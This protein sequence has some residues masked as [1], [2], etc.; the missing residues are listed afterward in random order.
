M[1]TVDQCHDEMTSIF[2]IISPSSSTLHWSLG[3][4]LK[5]LSVVVLCLDS[6]QKASIANHRLL[7]RQLFNCFLIELSCLEHSFDCFSLL[8]FNLTGLYWG[9]NCIYFDIPVL[10]GFL[11][12]ALWPIYPGTGNLSI[13]GTSWMLLGCLWYCSWMPWLM[14]CS[15]ASSCPSIDYAVVMNLLF[16]WSGWSNSDL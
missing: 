2:H 10:M 8:Q 7:L 3:N 13:G 12:T 9:L 16:R 11:K 4:F 15:F 6:L 14:S 5:R 1:E